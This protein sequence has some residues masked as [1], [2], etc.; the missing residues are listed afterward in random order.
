MQQWLTEND[1][2]AKKASPAGDW[3]SFSIPVSK[4]NA[5]L[6]A[7][8]TEFVHTGTGETS[9]RTLAYSIPAD[10]KGH[11][12]FVHPTTVYVTRLSIELTSADIATNHQSFYYLVLCRRS[13]AP[14][15][16]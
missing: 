15:S 7:D 6:D 5:L 2:V 14:R 8:F 1:I 16:S 3:L 10:L 11:L 4:A 13:L 12:D 9:I